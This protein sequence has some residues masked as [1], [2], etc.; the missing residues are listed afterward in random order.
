MMYAFTENYVLP[1]SHDEV[2]HGKGS[3]IGKMPGS[4][5]EKFAGVRCFLGYT[6]AHPGKKL[7]FMGYEFGQF[8]EW[9]FSEGLEFFLR[10]RFELHGKLSLF[11]K[12]LNHLYKTTMPFFEVD[13]GWAGFEWL[14]ADDK[15]RN[16]VA[17]LRRDKAGRE[18]LAVVSF[19]GADANDYMLGV[20]VRGKYRLI[21]N[22]DDV[23]YGGR[24]MLGKRKVFRAIQYPTHGK[25]Y[26]IRLPM[27]KLTCLY[28]VKEG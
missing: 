25:Q 24:G 8:K 19:S 7:N 28:L 23:K 14:A 16:I 10:D 15:D 26:S 4:Y 2:V 3:L 11:V 9:D 27:P 12:E 17:F 5:E 21:F 22:S 13:D 20:N 18:V 1:I 6:I